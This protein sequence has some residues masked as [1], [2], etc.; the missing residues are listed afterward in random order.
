MWIEI[1]SDR[2]HF[3]IWFMW[4][5]GLDLKCRGRGDLIWNL[6]RKK[7]KKTPP[8]PCDAV[9]DEAESFFSDFFF[10]YEKLKLPPF[11]GQVH[12]LTYR[13]DSVWCQK[14]V[15]IGC[16]SSLNS[17]RWCNWRR[18]GGGGG[19]LLLL[20]HLVSCYLL[21]FCQGSGSRQ[22]YIPPPSSSSSPPQSSASPNPGLMS[23]TRGKILHYCQSESVAVTLAHVIQSLMH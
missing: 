7:K 22:V 11:V 21:S 18:G 20:F 1:D 17:W 23:I 13:G 6:S 10:L 2:A 12:L 8:P 9:V 3:D 4:A 15:S 14:A 16:C 19:A 5:G